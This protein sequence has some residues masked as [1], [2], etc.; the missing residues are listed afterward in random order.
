MVFNINSMS[1]QGVQP[2]ITVDYIIDLL[3]KVRLNGLFSSIIN[4]PEK[5]MIT[6]S[7]V[8]K[9]L[10]RGEKVDD[11]DAVCSSPVRLSEKVVKMDK[12]A[13]NPT[14]DGGWEDRFTDYRLIKFSGSDL[15]VDILQTGEFVDVINKTGL[16]PVNSLVLT[17]GGIRHI[18]EVPEI[19]DRLNVKAADPVK[20]RTWM[21]ENLKA[22]KVC[23][24]S[25]MREKDKQYFKDWKVI[26]FQECASH[27]IYDKQAKN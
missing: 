13:Y 22:G 25:D 26:D 5:P 9:H 8:Y 6:G 15:H 16:S 10:V 24:W 2:R 23:R 12:L 11:V 21:V 7:Y 18:T 4:G 3:Q 17:E 19:A 14:E 20:E 27:G 1:N